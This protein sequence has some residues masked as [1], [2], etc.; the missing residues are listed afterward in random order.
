M[1]LIIPC[2]NGLSHCP[3]EFAEINDI[4]KGTSIITKMILDLA[5]Q[6]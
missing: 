6:A 2:K 3:E 4:A 1:I 5:K